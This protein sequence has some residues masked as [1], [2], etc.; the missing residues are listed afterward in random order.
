MKRILTIG[1]LAL[2]VG[3]GDKKVG[4]TFAR[5]EFWTDPQNGC[6]YVV[7]DGPYAGGITARLDPD[8]KP[9]C[10]ESAP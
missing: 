10:V 4:G 9:I 5:F 1:L 8:G 2:L 7:Y 6:Q 3:C